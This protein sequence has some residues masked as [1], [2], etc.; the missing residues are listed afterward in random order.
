MTRRLV[1]RA[2]AAP[3]PAPVVDNPAEAPDDDAPVDSL[4][5]VLSQLADSAN[6]NI[7]VYRAE[8]GQKQAYVYQCSPDEFSLDVL[9]DKYNGGTFRLYISKNGAL[10]RNMVVVVEP[11]HAADPTPPTDAALMMARMQDMMAKQNEAIAAAIRSIAASAPPPPSPFANLS[12]PE[13]L[14][15]VTGLIAIVR[16]PAPPPTDPTGL[17]VKGIELATALKGDSSGGDSEP[18]VMGL[19]RDLIKSPLAAQAV[20]AATQAPPQVPQ[21]PAPQVSH[22]KPPQPGPQATVPQP[23]AQP[24]PHPAMPQQAAIMQQYLAILCQKASEGSDPALYA[25]LILDSLDYDTINGLLARQP[26][27]V[28][29]LI[30]DFPGVAAH[31]DWFE[32]LI[33]TIQSVGGDDTTADEIQSTYVEPATDHNAAAIPTSS[34]SGGNPIG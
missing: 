4:K 21:R 2:P 25:D 3:A 12:I 16:P 20:M 14:T 22:V 34:V 8:R 24:A 11:K 32:Q 28:D 10:W 6:S 9:R 33:A 30:A 23:P 19:L 26:T 7:T 5:S 27:P 31:R 18:T 17:L 15:A 1:A 13:L 29:A